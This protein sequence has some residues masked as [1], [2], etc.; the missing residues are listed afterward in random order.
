MVMAGREPEHRVRWP[1]MRQAWRDV[2]FVHWPYPVDEV[3]AQLPGGFAVDTYDDTAWVALSAFQVAACGIGPQAPLRL[4]AFPETNLRT[5]VVGPDGTDGIW[6]LTIEAQT[7][8]VTV[9][10]RLGFGAPYHHATM[11]V[12]RDGDEVRYTSRRHDTAEGPETGYDLRIRIGNQ[13]DDTDR[14]GLVDWCTGRWRAWTTHVG[15]QLR[16]AV[17][18][19]PWPLRHADVLDIEQ[20]LTAG[21]GLS[22]PTGA[23]LVHYS[24]G[25]DARLSAPRAVLL[26]RPAGG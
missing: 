9:G 4:W 17:H 23:P 11:R 19:Q 5:Y 15:L 13:V 12:E 10:A 1:V 14:T 8:A 21:V 24:A 2:A 25:V 7:R 26:R 3:A 16:S 22:P 6:F 18:H 20:T